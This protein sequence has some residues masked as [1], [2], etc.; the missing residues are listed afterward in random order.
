MKGEG[1][2]YSEKQLREGR[3]GFGDGRRWLHKNGDRW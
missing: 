2:I 1:H 3:G